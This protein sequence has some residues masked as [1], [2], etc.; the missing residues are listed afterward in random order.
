MRIRELMQRTGVTERQVRYLITEG[1]M[2]GPSGGRANAA[3]DD[4]HVR[5]I[6]R[7]GRLHELGFPPAAIK[8][9][10]A[11]RDGT[12]LP[13]APGITLLVSPDIIAS[14]LD[15]QPLVQQIATVLSQVLERDDLK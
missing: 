11:A 15:P 9:L 4:G 6:Q 7:Y 13:I 1:F 12:P 2:P 14:G 5:T 10:L 8:L 3:Y